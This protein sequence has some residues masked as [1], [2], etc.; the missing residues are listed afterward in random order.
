MSAW[1][2]VGEIPPVS[3]KLAELQP[4]FAPNPFS[5]STAGWFCGG[6]KDHLKEDI[7][8]SSLHTQ[9]CKSQAEAQFTLQVQDRIHA[10]AYLE[11]PL[12][13]L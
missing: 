4:A 1:G 2:V 12:N 7:N 3:P 5:L 13:N 8:I 11:E 10:N 6:E 9:V